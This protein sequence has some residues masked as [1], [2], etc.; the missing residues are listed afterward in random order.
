MIREKALVQVVEERTSENSQ[1]DQDNSVC[2]AHL[3]VLSRKSRGPSPAELNL[4]LLSRVLAD[5]GRGMKP[6]LRQ[7]T[8]ANRISF[9]ER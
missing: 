1:L 9:S 7:T 5:N 4:T 6:D 2:P 3:V 8:D